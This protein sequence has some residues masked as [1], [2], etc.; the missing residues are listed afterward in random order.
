MTTR[1]PLQGMNSIGNR[2]YQPKSPMLWSRHIESHNLRKSDVVVVIL[3]H[4]S[5]IRTIERSLA[6][7]VS[8]I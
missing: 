4:T 2:G 7:T 3:F 1:S 5:A 6:I 8:Q